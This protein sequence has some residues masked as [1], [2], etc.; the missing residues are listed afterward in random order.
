[1]GKRAWRPDASSGERRSRARQPPDAAL[2]RVARALLVRLTRDDVIELHDH[3]GAEVALDLHD[4]LRRE[5]VLR[6]VDVAAELHALFAHGAQ[7][8]ERE[9]LEAA[10]VGEDRAVPAHERVQPAERG[11]DIVARAQMQMIRV[12]EDHLRAGV[13]QVV[14]VERL[15]RR[16]SAHRHEAGVSTVPCGV[17]NTPARAAAHVAAM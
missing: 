17:A 3:V 13:A 10:R 8:L 5:H 15:H 11:D 6:A 16:V 9:H 7:R 1:M 4:G 14:G 2:T 12:G